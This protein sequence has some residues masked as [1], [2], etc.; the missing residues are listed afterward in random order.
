MKRKLPEILTEN[1]VKELLSIPNKRYRT[2]LRN[3]LLMKVA[4]QTGMRVSELINLKRDDIDFMTGKTFIRQAKGQKDRITFI[5]QETREEI[6][7]LWEKMNISSQN[8][9]STL[10]G[11]IIDTG[12]LR[13]S[14]KKYAGKAGITKRAYFHLLRHTALT[15]LYQETHD[16]RLIQEIAGHRDISTTMI[17][18]HISGEEIKGTL[19]NKGFNL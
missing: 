16:I 1:E 13:K 4:V 9:F 19:L 10:E 11:S 3:Y 8:C 2:G 7:K 6:I 18:T 17:Y 5:K 12:Y 14:I 15:K